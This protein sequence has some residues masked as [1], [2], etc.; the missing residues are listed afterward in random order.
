[1]SNNT[2]QDKAVIRETIHGA[3]PPSC[4]SASQLNLYNDACQ[5]AATLALAGNSEL[6]NKWQQIATER[7]D[8]LIAAWPVAAIQNGPS[9][10]RKPKA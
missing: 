1:M 10:D 7:L 2:D 4:A 6:A 3:M 5:K 8:G 9:S